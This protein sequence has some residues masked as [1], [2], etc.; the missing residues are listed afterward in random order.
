VKMDNDLELA[1]KTLRQRAKAL[2]PY[3]EY[4]EGDHPLVYSTARLREVF[5]KLDANF[6]ENW[7]SVIINVP[8]ERLV[9]ERLEVA[10]DEAATAA[11]QSLWAR[12]DLFLDADEVHK[13]ALIAGESFSLAWEDE[14][15]PGRATAY[16]H[17][18]RNCTVFYEAENPRKLR[19]AAKWWQ[20][21]QRYRLNLYY[22]DRIQKYATGDM[23]HP[24]DSY[25]AFQVFEEQPNPYDTVPVFHFTTGQGS[26]LKNAVP[27]QASI[28][29]LLSDA[30]VAAEFSAFRQRYI[31]SQ[32]DPGNFKNS[33]NEIWLVPAGD[34][35]G[36]QTQVGEFQGTD[37]GNYETSIERRIAA[38]S[39]IGRIPSHYFFRG[40]QPPSGEALIALEAPLNKLVDRIIQRMTVTWQQQAAFMLRIEGVEVDPEAV[41]VRYAD[42]E[43]VQPRTRAEIRQLNVA[44]GMPLVTALRR[45]GWTQEELDQ[46]GQDL[47]QDR[48]AR[49]AEES[50]LGGALL[51][52]FE[53][54]GF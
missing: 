18:P 33:P 41:V 6:V 27:I 44:A 45:D 43:T 48:D 4:Y 37:L 11:L 53:R 8:W 36:Q 12:L 31:I 20:D 17:D 52:R 9:L 29:K 22:P 1:Y 38:L 49:A 51:T 30:M 14:D 42:P 19:L 2:T 26:L 50:N 16:P 3:F 25:T 10:D 7:C 5:R 40:G 35:Q 21:G 47:A 13:D 28:N 15:A 39:S 54:G 23:Q 24:P 46:L 32:A 34:G